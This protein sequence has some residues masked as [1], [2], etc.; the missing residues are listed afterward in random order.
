MRDR[1]VGAVRGGTVGGEYVYGGEY[2][3]SVLGD[4]V[5]A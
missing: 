1:R 3:G 4:S 5:G 2:E